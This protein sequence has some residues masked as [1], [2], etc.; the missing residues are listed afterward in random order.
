MQIENRNTTE[1]LQVNFVSIQMKKQM[2]SSRL[3]G[4]VN[5]LRAYNDNHKDMDYFIIKEIS[6]VICV[7]KE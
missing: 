2:T 7:K 5:N 6:K 3:A 1:Q 4:G